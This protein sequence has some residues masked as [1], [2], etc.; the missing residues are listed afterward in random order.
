MPAG[1]TRPGDGR[2]LRV[3][4]SVRGPVSI[5]VRHVCMDG[6]LTWLTT[7]RRS[8]RNG[9]D[10]WTSVTRCSTHEPADPAMH[11]DVPRRLHR[12]AA[13][14]AGRDAPPIPDPSPQGTSGE[15]AQGG[16]LM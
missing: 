9:A 13:G 7:S 6:D 1:R 8:K 2:D 12:P 11:V 4:S 15:N 3:R 10:R 16:V 5:P 14:G